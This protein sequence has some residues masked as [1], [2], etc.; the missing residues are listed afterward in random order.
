MVQLLW[1]QF[2]ISTKRNIFS[3][4]DPAVVLISVF[5]MNWKLGPH[6]N[7]HTNISSTFIHNYPKLEQTKKSFI[8]EWVNYGTYIPWSINYSV[9]KR[10]E[11]MMDTRPYTSVITWWTLMSK[12][13]LQLIIMFQYWF[14]N[15]NKHTTLI[16]VVNCE[17]VGR[18]GLWE[19]SVLSDLF[20]CN[21]NTA[22]KKKVY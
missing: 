8:S 12:C 20:F 6:K 16:Q 3:P 7:M 18:G 13:G 5:L 14:V 22:L 21:P 17:C 4:H 9:I 2:A 1:R 11:L 10:K 15:Y 19:L